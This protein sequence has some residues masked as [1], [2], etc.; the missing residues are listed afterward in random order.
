M[1]KDNSNWKEE[2]GQNQSLL[3]FNLVYICGCK[4]MCVA[5]SVSI[6]GD[7]ACKRKD[8]RPIDGVLSEEIMEPLASCFEMKSLPLIQVP[9]I[10]LSVMKSLPE[11]SH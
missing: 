9:L 11:P 1:R 10:M 3:W 4:F 5:F 7:R 6:L 2:Q 8:L